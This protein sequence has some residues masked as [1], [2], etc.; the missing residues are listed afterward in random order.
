[1]QRPFLFG[2]VLLEF[3]QGQIGGGGGYSILSK[4]K[5]EEL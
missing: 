1:M 5:G 4:I 3:F 2:F